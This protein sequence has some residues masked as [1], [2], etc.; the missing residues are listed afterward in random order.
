M[1]GL[2]V[3]I[4]T[5]SWFRLPPPVWLDN[6]VRV[7]LDRKILASLALWKLTFSESGLFVQSHLIWDTALF[8]RFIVLNAYLSD[9]NEMFRV[10]CFLFKL[11]WAHLYYS[12]PI[13]ISLEYSHSKKYF[14]CFIL[15]ITI[16]VYWLNPS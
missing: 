5:E 15:S 14:H 3:T 16:R 11:N 2:F 6:A 8:S 10:I 1:L 7:L 4:F 9:N 12:L 13:R